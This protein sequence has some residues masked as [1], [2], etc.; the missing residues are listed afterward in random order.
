[1]VLLCAV[2]GFVAYELGR[3]SHGAKPRRLWTPIVV[4]PTGAETA[5]EA[6]TR[7]MEF[8]TPS[9]RTKDHLARERG[10]IPERDQWEIISSDE[11]VQQFGALLRTN[12][13][14]LGYRRAEVWGHGRTTLK[15][16]WWW[17]MTV[18][19]NYSVQTFIQAYRNFWKSSNAVFVEVI[20]NPAG[21]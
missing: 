7:R 2:V 11:P 1:V 19:T 13:S 21:E 5:L 17:T 18:M 15:P 20:E 9:G 4:T 3:Q 16:G 10:V 14:V 12:V 6:G 8:W